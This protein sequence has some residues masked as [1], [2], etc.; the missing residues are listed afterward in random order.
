MIYDG[1]LTWRINRSK[2]IDHHVILFDDILV[3]LQKQDDRLV[4][5]CQSGNREPGKD[6]S[7][8]TH[9]HSPII[10]LNNVLTR[11]VAVGE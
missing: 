11:N 1:V 6:D 10:K 4:L 2:H 9:T 7:K 5:R 8:L 3:L